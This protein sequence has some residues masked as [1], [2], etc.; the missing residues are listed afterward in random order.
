MKQEKELKKQNKWREWRGLLSAIK[1]KQVPKG[2]ERLLS[3][4]GHI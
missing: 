1:K 3:V 4:E 2:K